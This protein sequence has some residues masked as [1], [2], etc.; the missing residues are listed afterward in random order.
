MSGTRKRPPRKTAADPRR[1]P[2][3]ECA[4]I[5]KRRRHRR[6][7]RKCPMRR[8]Q[9]RA[10]RPQPPS[11]SSCS[12]AHERR[13]CN[14]RTSRLRRRPRTMRRMRILRFLRI[15]TVALRF[16]LDDILLSHERVRF[17]RPWVA[18]R[19]C[20]GATCRRRARCACASR[21]K[22]W[23]RS[24][25]SSGRCCPRAATSCRRTSPTSS[26]SCR[27]RVPPFPAEEVIATLDRC[28]RRPVDEVFATFDRTPTASASVAQVHFA[29]AA[30]RHA[31][32]GE[33]AAA[34]ASRT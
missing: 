13:P 17:L 8:S 26:R 19:C 31:G 16:G 2:C 23:A 21:S 24:S 6:T 29:H 14:R 22:R 11:P 34:R 20:S 27:T 3:R 1:C 12:D 28:Y 4:A 32:R 5:R 33:G 15:M 30:Q 9:S 25:S 18:P 10:T 7:H